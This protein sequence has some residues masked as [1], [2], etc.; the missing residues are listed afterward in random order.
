MEQ[1]LLDSN[2]EPVRDALVEFSLAGHHYLLLWPEVAFH[3][4]AITC[5]YLVL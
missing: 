4:S 1:T 3:S 5:A 2:V